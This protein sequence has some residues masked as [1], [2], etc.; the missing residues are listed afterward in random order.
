MQIPIQQI[1]PLEEYLIDSIDCKP[2]ID[3]SFDAEGALE[4]YQR[5]VHSRAD[6]EKRV[7]SEFE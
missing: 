5:G 7:I 2:E 3:D 1:Q 4:T 6:L